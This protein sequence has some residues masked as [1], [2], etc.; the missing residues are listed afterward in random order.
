MKRFQQIGALT[1][2]ADRL[3]SGLSA[4]IRYSTA[5][6]DSVLQFIVSG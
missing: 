1:D 3:L 5:Y 2:A 4:T 6:A